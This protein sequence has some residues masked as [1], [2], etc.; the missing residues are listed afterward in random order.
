M[1]VVLTPPPSQEA[2]RPNYF[3]GVRCNSA[4]VR[5]AA[6]ALQQ[7]AVSMHEELSESLV[8]IHRL[9]LTLVMLALHAPDALEQ[10]TQLMHSA[11]QPLI[12]EHFPEGGMS[13]NFDRVG[14]FSNR[15]MWIGAAADDKREKFL[16][17]RNAVEKVFI[18]AKLA[19]ED[20]EYKIHGTLF[21]GSVRIPDSVVEDLASSACGTETFDFVEL[22]PVGKYDKS[23]N[24]LSTTSCNVRPLTEEEERTALGESLYIKVAAQHQVI[25]GRIAGM[26]LD[27]HSVAE[28]KTIMAN[29]AQYAS[30]VTEAVAVLHHAQEE[31]AQAAKPVHADSASVASE[32]PPD[33]E[34]ASMAGDEPA[35]IV[36]ITTWTPGTGNEINFSEFLVY[37][38]A[39][40]VPEH[41]RLQNANPLAKPQ[42]PGH[43]NG[44]PLRVGRYV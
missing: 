17:F 23:G 24:Y 32:A 31:A 41:L 26:L 11:V 8:P 3:I 15:V 16:A 25:A 14:H 38:Q 5:D 13:I 42:W 33:S 19:T 2:Q 36:D 6:S 29:E 21:K 37:R 22:M 44:R 27:S 9:H 34:L 10:A 28:L 35:R 30:L 4:E 18:E 20:D 12:K 39:H 43:F 40:R 1:S 7:R